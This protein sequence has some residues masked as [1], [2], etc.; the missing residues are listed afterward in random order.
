[1]RFFV[2]AS[3]L[4]LI[5]FQ[6]LSDPLPSWE[7]TDA[8]TAIIDFVEAVTDP[9]SEYYVTPADRIATID[10]DGTLWSEQPVYFQLI[11]ALDRLREKAKADPSI[12]TTD[13]LRAAAEGDIEAIAAGGMEAL[14]DVLAVSHS[15]ISA[16]D[17]EADVRAWLQGARHPTTGLLYTDMVFQ[18]MLELLRYLRDEGFQ[19]WIVSGGGIHFV[20][21]FAQEAYNIPPE[22]VIGSATPTEYADGKIIKQAG[23]LFVDDKAGKPLGIDTHI[24]KRPIFAAG[25]S[26]GDFEMLEY[27]FAGEGPRFGM[28]VHHTDGEREFAYDREG[29][30]G[31]LNRG[32]DE[33]P[34]RGWIIVDMATDWTRIWSR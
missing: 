15:D 10:N 11:Y 13:V 24:G 7:E 30:I 29:H 25:N 21:A 34:D 4:S 16:K 3:A 33:G 18:P 31:V 5:T 27:T 22:Q 1:M 8:K 17:F 19:T 6:A 23:I 32:L 12:L 14:L 2:I 9:A 28:L 20:R 26:D